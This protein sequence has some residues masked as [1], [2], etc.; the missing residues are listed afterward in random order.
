MANV[1]ELYKSAATGALVQVVE[2]GEGALAGDLELVKENTTDAATEKHVPVV[3]EI[4][5]GYLVM[6]GS[7]EHPMTEA[8]YIEW[9]ELVTEKEVLRRY[10]TPND[11]PMAEFKTDEKALYAR[12][13][14]NVHGIWKS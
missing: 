6:V 1:N 5:G 3:Q 11:K 12:E 9:I 7:V 4:E 8:H 13:H 10:L 14:C 2:A